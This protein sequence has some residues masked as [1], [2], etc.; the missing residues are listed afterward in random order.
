MPAYLLICR[1]RSSLQQQSW[2]KTENLRLIFRCR[3]RLWSQRLFDT[4]E[5]LQAGSWLKLYE[6]AAA[7]LSDQQREKHDYF[8]TVRDK[9]IAHSALLIFVWARRRAG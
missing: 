7:I 5:P 1:P 6:E 8:M 4:P 9:Y 2:K 3:T